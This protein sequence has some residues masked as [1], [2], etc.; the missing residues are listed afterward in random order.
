LE[1]EW[2]GSKLESWESISLPYPGKDKHDPQKNAFSKQRGGKRRKEDRRRKKERKKKE[3][4][5][6]THL[7]SAIPPAKLNPPF[8]SNRFSVI[9]SAYLNK[10]GDLCWS[11]INSINLEDPTPACSDNV[12]HSER[13]SMNPSSR[14]FPTSLLL[15]AKR[16][17]ERSELRSGGDGLGRSSKGAGRAQPEA[18]PV[19]EQRVGGR[20]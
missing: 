10:A 20:G 3:E 2:E 12:K 4:R 6:K 14:A 5:R 8:E 16:R 9:L 7:A 19:A 15:A 1:P 18:E 17:S 11:L 13:S